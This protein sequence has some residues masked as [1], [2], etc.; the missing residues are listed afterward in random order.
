[1]A[2]WVGQ[3]S[4]AEI[5]ANIGNPPG[6]VVAY[7]LCVYQMGTSL[8]AAISVSV[9]GTAQSIM[10]TVDGGADTVT[11]NFESYVG[12]V[13]ANAPKYKPGDVLFTMTRQGTKI[14][15]QWG[16]MKPKLSAHKTPGSYFSQNAPA[17]SPSASPSA[18]G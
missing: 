5:D 10:A 13:P 4:Y 12:K 14:T 16:S 3:Y 7:G 1:L 9:F 2:V 15:T 11:V 17:A 18:T 8:F 6:S